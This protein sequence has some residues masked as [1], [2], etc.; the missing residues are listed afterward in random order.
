[1]STD[2]VNELSSDAAIWRYMAFDR[3]VSMLEYSSLWFARPFTFSDQWEGL[4]PPSYYR[5][6]QKWVVDNNEKW[7]DELE[8][9]F[10]KRW[11]RHR[12]ATF[13]NCW[14]IGVHE[15]DAMCAC[16]EKVWQFNPPWADYRSVFPFTIAVGLGITIQIKT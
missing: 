3:I 2:D 15:S 6:A 9:E 4:Y 13:V 7:D 8:S 1:M 11:K 14:H 10:T 16:M 5:N 12:F